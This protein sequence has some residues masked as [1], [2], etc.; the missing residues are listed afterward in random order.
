MPDSRIKGQEVSVQLIVNNVIRDTINDVRNFEMAPQFEIIREG[1]LGETSDRRDEVYRGIRG[2][3]ELHFENGDVF[4]LFNQ[5]RERAKR[6]T[7][8][9]TINVK[10]TLELPSGERQVVLIPNV[11][12]GEA[13]IAFGSRTDYGTVGLDFEAQD[14]EPLAG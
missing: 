4:R 5:V 6:R 7:P 10:A 11:F 1:Y 14:Y 9:T 13:P 12:F 2:R 3:L 8:G